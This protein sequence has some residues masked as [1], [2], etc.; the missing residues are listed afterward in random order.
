MP[1]TD[2]SG[3]LTDV[4]SEI[5]QTSEKIASAIVGVSKVAMASVAVGIVGAVL[6]DLANQP[7]VAEVFRQQV[8]LKIGIQLE[9]EGVEPT[10]T[11]TEH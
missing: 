7:A 2:L 1:T 6:E 9:T 3:G 8:M 10:P 5:E 11:P 4:V